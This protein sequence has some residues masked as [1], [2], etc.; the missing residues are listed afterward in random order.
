[1][2]AWISQGLQ[3]VSSSVVAATYLPWWGRL[4]GVQIQIQVLH[5]LV[6]LGLHHRTTPTIRSHGRNQLQVLHRPG[7]ERFSGEGRGGHKDRQRP[8]GNRTR[9]FVYFDGVVTIVDV[10]WDGMWVAKKFVSF[11]E[12][13]QDLW[14]RKTSPRGEFRSRLRINSMLQLS[15]LK[16]AS[17]LKAFLQHALH[18]FLCFGHDMYWYWY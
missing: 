6:S 3:V 13:T 2:H 16:Y 5:L 14:I 8:C 12:Y 15:F 7:R 1:M 17:G 4:A 10:W 9:V 11:S 18:D